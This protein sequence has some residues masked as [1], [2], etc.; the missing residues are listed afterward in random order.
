MRKSIIGT[1]LEFLLDRK[2][3]GSDQK[4]SGTIK[5]P[6]A[7]YDP[8]LQTI[9]FLLRKVKKEELSEN[10]RNLLYCPELYEKAMRDG[11]EFKC[12]GNVIERFAVEDERFSIMICI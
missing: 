3:S 10:E 4:S 1:F 11:L 2:A 5:Y 9:D 8:L 12:I 6:A 7:N